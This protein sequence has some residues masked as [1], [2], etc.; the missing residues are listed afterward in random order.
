MVATRNLPG[1]L[2]TMIAQECSLPTDPVPYLSIER[3]P[4]GH[5]EFSSELFSHC[6]PLSHHYSMR[7]QETMCPQ[8]RM[9]TCYNIMTNTSSPSYVKLKEFMEKVESVLL[10]T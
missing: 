6:V 9:C 4:R 5:S 2:A 1:K 10:F 7:I 3:W 8:R